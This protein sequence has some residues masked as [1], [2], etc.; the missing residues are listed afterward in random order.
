MQ[1]PV[2]LTACWL[3]RCSSLSTTTSS[4][5]ESVT[6]QAQGVEDDANVKQERTFHPIYND[7][8][9]TDLVL[10]SSDQVL[11]RVHSVVLSTASAVFRQMMGVERDARESSETP[12]QMEETAEVLQALLDVF[13]PDRL[14]LPPAIGCG[15]PSGQGGSLGRGG[16]GKAWRQEQLPHAPPFHIL[17]DLALAADKYDM[18]GV[19]RVVR[20]TLFVPIP[21]ASNANNLAPGTSPQVQ[22]ANPQQH[23]PVELYALARRLEWDAEAR[24]AS[25]ATLACTPLVGPGADPTC[26]RAVKAMDAASAVGLLELHARRRD[27]FVAALDLVGAATRD[28]DSNGDAPLHVQR[29]WMG[30]RIA[31]KG[32]R[33][34]MYK[35]KTM[36]PSRSLG[37][38]ANTSSTSSSSN[39][40][41]HAGLPPPPAPFG[42]AAAA[43]APPTP[44]T[45]TAKGVSHRKDALPCRE[46]LQTWTTFAACALAELDRSLVGKALRS[47]AFWQREAFGNLWT[48]ACP[49]VN[50][51]MQL[52]SRTSLKA[53]L[54]RD[55]DALP[56]TI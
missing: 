36:S 14:C 6:M 8:E 22:L 7:A 12:V 56:S 24:A 30:V 47:D 9:T 51:S 28:F 11:F 17:R 15:L 38:R 37:D 39:P 52:V 1:S 50:C 53:A 5:V 23:P 31:H 13:Y 54:V 29:Y 27:A 10:A 33:W 44:T 19:M 34:N 3:Q 40:Q 2:A 35:D 41:G 46:H 55:L 43:D 45:P 21:Q 25:T 26:T 16:G 48:L 20:R 49:N 32:C 4:N 18:P 42:V